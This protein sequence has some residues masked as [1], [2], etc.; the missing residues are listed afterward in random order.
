MGLSSHNWR[1]TNTEGASNSLRLVNLAECA[2]VVEIFELNVV[3]MMQMRIM[4]SIPEEES[5]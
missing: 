3:S 4:D 2:E 1:E 5:Q